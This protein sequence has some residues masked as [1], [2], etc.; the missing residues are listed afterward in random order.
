MVYWI[1]EKIG[2]QSITESFECSESISYCFLLNLNDGWN[3]PRAIYLIAKK[4]LSLLYNNK[5]IILVCYAGIS[6]SNGLA[7][8]LLAYLKGCSLDEAYSF[9]KDKVPRAQ[10]N[11]DFRDSCAET[12]KLLREKLVKKCSCKSPIEEW[13]KYCEECWIRGS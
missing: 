6:R 1:T 8:L 2:T 9:V 7:A 12:L 3:P 13:E 5:R 10:V 11:L 4:C